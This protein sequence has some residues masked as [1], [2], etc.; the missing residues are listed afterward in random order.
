MAGAWT[1]LDIKD[2]GGDARTM[3][4]WDESGTGDGPFSFAHIASDGLGAGGEIATAAKQD[5]EATLV[6]ALT[7]TGPATDTASSGLNGRLQRIAQRLTSLIA[8]TLATS[9]ADGSNVTLG[10]KA[11]A[12]SIA[13]DTT[14]ISA[15]SVW[16]QISSSVQAIATSLTNILTSLVLAAGENHIGSIGGNTVLM[17][18]TLS[19]DTSI[20]ASGDVIADTQQVANALRVNDGTGTLKSLVLIDEDDQGAAMDIYVFN[21]SGAMGTE[22]SAPSISDANARNFLARIPVA[23]GDWIDLGGVRIADLTALCGQVLKAASGTK[24]LYVAAVNGTGTPTFTASGL[25]L[26]LG[27]FQD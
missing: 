24:D 4:V 26:R 2:G 20:F 8:S 18:V 27:I 22:N 6:G 11:D 14:A 12:K 10:A 16:K 23:S 19:A 7:E 21:G 17:D 15:M 9:A 25:K 5:A 13:T 3:R 1:T